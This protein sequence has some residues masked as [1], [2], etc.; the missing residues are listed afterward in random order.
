MVKKIF[1]IVLILFNTAVFAQE[2]CNNGI[3]DDGDGLIDC[4]DP[5]CSGNPSCSDF[6]YG[7]PATSCT[8]SP[9]NPAFSLNLIWQSSLNVSTRSTMMVGDMDGDG[10]PEV[11]C[12]QDGANQLY[13]LDGRTGN[14]EV[15]INCPPIDDHVDAIAIGDTDG[16]GL[17]EIYVVTSDNKIRC[18]EN[19]GTPKVGYVPPTASFTAESIPGIAD[20]NGD[21]IPEIYKDNKIYNSLTGALIASGTGSTG[22]NPG[23]NG[24]PASMPVAAD[25]LPAS[26]CADCAGLELVCGNVVYAVNISAGTLTPVAN[27]LPGSLN[28]GF[29]SVADMN[30]DGKLDIIVVSSGKVYVWDPRTGL[31]LGNTFTIP[32]TS[33]GGRANIADYD[34]DGFPEIGVGGYNV[35][36]VIDVNISTNAL[37]QKWIKTIVDGSE[38]TTGSAFDFDC[39]GTTEVV[40]RDE[41]NLYIWEGATGNVKASIQ[42][43]SATRSEFPTIVDVDGDGQV[44]IVCACA[45]SNAGAAG[46]VKAFNSSTNQWVGSRKVMNQHSYS[47]VNVNDNLSIPLQQQNS[48]ALP[49]TIGFLAQSPI[50]DVN[51]NSTCIPLPNMTVSITSVVYCQKPDTVVVGVKLCNIGSKVTS[52]PLNVSVYN[53]NP[54]SGGTLISLTPFAPFVLPDSCLNETIS[55]PFSGTTATFYVYVNDS[56]SSPANAPQTTFAECDSSDNSGFIPINVPVLLLSILGD[57]VIC[58][59]DATSLTVTG[60]TA[61]TK[62]VWSPATA[63]NTSFGNVVTANPLTTITYTIT[64]TDT[65]TGCHNDKSVTVIVNQKPVAAFSNTTV[66]NGLATQFT[67]SSSVVSATISSW[68]WNFGDSSPLATVQHP[69]HTFAN[70][71]IYIVKLVVTTNT[72]CQ[73]SISKSVS[74]HS[75]PS[76]L[77]LKQNVCEGNAVSFSDLATL[78]TN[79]LND[80]I[81]SW[82]W[83]FGDNSPLVSSRNTSHLYALAGSYSVQLLVVSNFGCSDSITKTVVVNPNPIVNFTANDTMGCE[84]LCVS[85]QNISSNNASSLWDLG[86]GSPGS[87]T[88]DQFHCYTNDSVFSPQLFT[89]ALTITSDSGCV[90]TKTKNN[91]ITVYP[92]PNANFSVLPQT[93]DII[94]PIITITNSSTGA[95]FWKWNFGNHDTASTQNP[96]P[97]TYADTGTYQITLITSTQYN[98]LDTA[99][100]TIIIEPDFTFFIPNAFSPNDD[101]VNDTF[102]GQGIFIKTFKMSIFDRWGNL[103]YQTDDINKPWDGKANHGTE[104][105]EQDVYVYVVTILDFKNRQHNYRGIVT[106]VR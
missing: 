19:D 33:A 68:L 81:Q 57:T 50:Y 35:Y 100:Q 38:H 6:F 83:N 73:D 39:D 29:T 22:N 14:V 16:D 91:Y 13:I 101:K 64:G 30:M 55:V 94:N 75:L 92:L 65:L 72:G 82:V 45:S 79:P 54:L 41:N 36:T 67:D 9:T 12:H 21:G 24:S 90:A 78:P 4:Y 37:S 102:T 15:T 43:G 71:G 60:G 18:F 87:S 104:I 59:G 99:Y 88:Q 62:Y 93:T 77:F 53:G 74:V 7:K 103:I 48:G 34:N 49:K 26:Y 1:C 23:S 66:C 27:S 3:D 44:N 89:V 85:F 69:S 61:A 5:D 70:S 97:L 86:D 105:A 25:V 10:T 32:G 46:Q 2:I 52:Q 17:G 98:C 84:P 95:N 31:Q 56:G 8:T 42:C 63:L 28:D 40:Y 80:T 11:V 58:K 20:F 76:A 106:L 47:V 51:W 96:G